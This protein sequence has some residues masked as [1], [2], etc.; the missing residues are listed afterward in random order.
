MTPKRAGKLEIPA[1]AL[2]I[3]GKRHMT[4][5]Q[6]VQ[7][8]PGGAPQSRNTPPQN[9]RQGQAQQGGP[10][11]DDL[12]IR[13]VVDKDTVYVNEQ[14]TLSFKFYQGIEL[15]QNT[16]YVPPQKTGF[17]VEELGP[18]KSS[19]QTVNGRDYRVTEIKSGLFP[20]APGVQS[21]GS[22]QPDLPGARPAAKPRSVFDFQ[23]LWSIRRNA[24]RQVSL[25]SYRSRRIAIADA[26][27][28]GRFRRCGWSIYDD[29]QCRPDKC[30]GK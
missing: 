24:E 27:Q 20:T 7:V 22:G 16:D 19:Y 9:R 28:A 25:G 18:Q 23:Q 26:R 15:L 10:T 11:R 4:P 8:D 5:A 30:A 13:T 29:R 14:I 1:F 21:I 3:D 2:E 17:W 12:F 6:Y